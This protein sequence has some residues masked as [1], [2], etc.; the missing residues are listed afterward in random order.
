MK[1]GNLNALRTA[2]IFVDAYC[3]GAFPMAKSRD[4]SDVHIVDPDNRAIIPLISFHVPRRFRRTIRKDPFQIRFNSDFKA[5][6]EAC[7]DREQTW[8]NDEIIATF[9]LLHDLGF[10]H[11]VEAWEGEELAG[12][13]Y[14]M[15]VRGAFFGESMFSRKS[16]ASKISLVYLADRLLQCNFE[17]LDAQFFTEHLSTFGAV[18]IT[19]GEFRSMLDRALRIEAVFDSAYPASTGSTVLQRISQTS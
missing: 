4:S 5:V 17:L 9:L 11:S 12:G 7:A 16:D 8:I 3:K 18:E 14:G 6:I 2:Y 15:A 1:S 10:A 19:R 13:L